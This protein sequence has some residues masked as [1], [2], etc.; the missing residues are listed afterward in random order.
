MCRESERELDQITGNPGTGLTPI[1][2]RGERRGKKKW[3]GCL[4]ERREE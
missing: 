1:P 3:R 4:D 2:T